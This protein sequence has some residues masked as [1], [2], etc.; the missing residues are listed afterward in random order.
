MHPRGEG[1]RLFLGPPHPL[2][3]L[4]PSSLQPHCCSHDGTLRCAEC[5]ML[6]CDFFL[7][8]KELDFH[9]FNCSKNNGDQLNTSHHISVTSRPGSLGPCLFSP[10]LIDSE[11]WTL[12]PRVILWL[13][14]TQLCRTTCYML[15]LLLCRILLRSQSPKILLAFFFM[16]LICQGSGHC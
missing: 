4:P 5:R 8:F 2:T 7:H 1:S 10:S 9:F 14:S 13:R 6:H 15:L 3:H 12:S 11:V 16:Q